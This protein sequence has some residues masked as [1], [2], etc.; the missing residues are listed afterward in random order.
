MVAQVIPLPSKFVVATNLPIFKDNIQAAMPFYLIVKGAFEKMN[1][2]IESDHSWVSEDLRFTKLY[3]AWQDGIQI[4]HVAEKIKCYIT[5]IVSRFRT[6]IITA[7][8]ED[9]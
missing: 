2:F 5:R 9:P 1:M 8:F 7:D 6:A 3:K 4:F